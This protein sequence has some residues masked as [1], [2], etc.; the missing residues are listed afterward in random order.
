MHKMKRDISSKLERM[1]E[2]VENLSREKV[3]YEGNRG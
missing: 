1:C 3:D 2:K